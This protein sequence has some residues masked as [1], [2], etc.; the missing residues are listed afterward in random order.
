[1]TAMNLDGRPRPDAA[2]RQAA[3]LF[4]ERNAVYGD[5]F[6]MVAN[7]LAAMFPDG[8][9]LRTR[10]DFAVWHNF[11]L[12]MVKVCRFAQSGLTHPDSIRDAAVYAAICD[13][14]K[15]EKPL[16]RAP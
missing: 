9:A 1:V 7:A 12:L 6:E 2:L 5:N 10:E 16:E 14:L 13:Y 4:A 11:E 3:V 8:V 15:Q